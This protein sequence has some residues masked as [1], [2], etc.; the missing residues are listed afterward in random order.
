MDINIA[1]ASG[2]AVM[3]LEAEMVVFVVAAGR[4]PASSPHALESV[5]IPALASARFIVVAGK[6]TSRRAI[7]HSCSIWRESLFQP[8]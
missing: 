3:L 5:A 6:V 8:S 1:A 7:R 2:E 4:T